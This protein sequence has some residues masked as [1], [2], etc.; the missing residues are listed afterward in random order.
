M[1]Q[2][3]SEWVYFIGNRSLDLLTS[4]I[5]TYKTRKQNLQANSR[6]ACQFWHKREKVVRGIAHTATLCLPQGVEIELFPSMGSH[7]QD[8]GRYSKLAYLGMKLGHWKKFQKLHLHSL[9]IQGVEFELIVALRVAVSEILTNFQNCFIWAKNLA[10]GKSC[11]KLHIHSF[12]PRGSKMSLFSFY[13]QRFVSEILAVFQNCHIWAGSFCIGKSSR[14]CTYALFLHPRGRNWVYFRSTG[15]S[16]RDIGRFSKL[17]YLGMKLGHWPKFQ[18]LHIYSLS[19]PGESKLS[20]FLLYGQPFWIY[21]R[22]F[23]ISI[24]AHEIWNLKTCPKVGYVL[25]FYARRSKLGLF[26]LYVQPFS[27]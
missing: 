14:I 20:L 25:S 4:L 9:S 3:V 15:S 26:L 27:R 19:S 5:K 13:G 18:K 16:F 24:F 17:P 7:F 23:K 12:Y 22:I 1:S 21:G 2:W 6:S 10:S 11:Q 8:T